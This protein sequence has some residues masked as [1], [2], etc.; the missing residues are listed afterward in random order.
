ML[1]SIKA[2]NQYKQKKFIKYLDDTVKDLN[3]DYSCNTCITDAKSFFI[4]HLVLF[5]FNSF[6]LSS[7]KSYDNS[8]DTKLFTEK[9]I[10]DHINYV[11]EEMFKLFI[12]RCIVTNIKILLDKKSCRIIANH[13]IRCLIQENILTEE[14][15]LF[16]NKTRKLLEI[17]T[18]HF[19]KSEVLHYKPYDSIEIDSE[20][21]SYNE[22]FST[23][24]NTYRNNIQSGESVKLDD[25]DN[26]IKN[27]LLNAWVYLDRKKLIR[28]YQILLLDFKTEDDLIKKDFNFLKQKYYSYLK[29]ND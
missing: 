5:L 17:N 7:F 8:T 6:S 25:A 4:T 11:I 13:V 12:A 14:N 19:E 29:R 2:V 21:Y 22:H 9:D 18:P 10:N 24:V 1:K 26:F 28:A 16:N 3:F 23:I 27:N 15:V 20:Y